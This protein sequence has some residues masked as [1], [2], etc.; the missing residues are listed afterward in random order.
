MAFG[1][2]RMSERAAQANTEPNVST[3]SPA[4]ELYRM[5]DIRTVQNAVEKLTTE[6]N[7][8]GRDVVRLQTKQENVEDELKLVRNDVKDARDRLG[9]LEERVRHLPSKGFIIVVV[10]SGLVI[11]GG[12]ATIAP[13]LQE[14]FGT[15]PS[16]VAVPAHVVAPPI[17]TQKQR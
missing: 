11:G 4:A 17:P 10:T 7:I 8:L 9:V 2:L 15:A 5:A 14:W 6:S 1:E 16:V 13:K 12:I 3:G